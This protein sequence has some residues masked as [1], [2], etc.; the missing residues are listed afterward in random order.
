MAE[1]TWVCRFAWSYVTP[2]HGIVISPYCTYNWLS[3]TCLV[4]RGTSWVENRQKHNRTK[5]LGL[6]QR[7]NIHELLN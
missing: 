3:K 1:N 5:V 7:S 6:S 2:R 4:G